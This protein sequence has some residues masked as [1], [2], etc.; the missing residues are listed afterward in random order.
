MQCMMSELTRNGIAL[1]HP[2]ACMHAWFLR[3]ITATTHA[4]RPLDHTHVPPS[5]IN[6][7]NSFYKK[8][9]THHQTVILKCS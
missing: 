4:C 5:H 1:P 6:N 3:Y 8:F 7:H 2:P 9:L